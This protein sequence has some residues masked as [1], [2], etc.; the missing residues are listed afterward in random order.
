DNG[1]KGAGTVCGSSA[2][3]ECGQ[4]DTGDGQGAYASNHA[5]NGTHCGD[6]ES[7]CVNQDTCL[8]GA[9]HDNGFKGAG[10]ACGSSASGECD[11][12]D[13]CDGQGACASNNAPNGT[14][15]GDPESACVNQDT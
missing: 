6:P 9:C 7:A 1:F 5:P 8:D 4:P 12:P 15:C 10:T 3:G 2:S 11:Q 13:T 14:H